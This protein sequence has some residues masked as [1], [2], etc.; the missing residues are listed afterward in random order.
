M[1]QRSANECHGRTSFRQG[2]RDTARNAG[3]AASHERNAAT[4][5]SV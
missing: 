1:F 4:E 3:A 5:N 2:S